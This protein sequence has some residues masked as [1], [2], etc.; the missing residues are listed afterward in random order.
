MLNIGEDDFIPLEEQKYLSDRWTEPDNAALPP[1]ILDQI[2]IIRSEKSARLWAYFYPICGKDFSRLIF[3]S[4]RDEVDMSKFADI[5]HYSVEKSDEE[6][7]SW[8]SSL[9]IPATSRMAFCWETNVAAVT[10]W[11]I[12]VK[13]WDDFYYPGQDDIFIGSL[14]GPWRLLFFHEGDIVYGRLVA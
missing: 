9:D 3:P 4:L 2:K 14:E 11:K 13:Y 5:G 6:I 10:T 7:F 8:L 12:F 1:R